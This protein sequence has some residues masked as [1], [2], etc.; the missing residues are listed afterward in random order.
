MSSHGFADFLEQLQADSRLVR[1]DA[2]IQKQVE[3]AVKAAEI[4]PRSTLF[5]DVAGAQFPLILGIFLSPESVSAAFRASS[6]DEIAARIDELVTGDKRISWL[7]RLGGDRSAALR[8]HQPRPLRTGP[9]QQIVH[10]GRDVDLGI[11]P[12]PLFHTA[13][14]YPALTAGR[15]I[16]RG[17]DDSQL[18]V[19]SHEF[20][21]V[22]TDR[23]V[24]CWHPSSQPARFLARFE[25]RGKAMPIVIA[26]GGDPAD[27]L[28]AMAPLPRGTDVLELDGYLRGTPCEL[29]QGRQVDLPVP[30][31]AEL[32]IEGTIAPGNNCT[33]A[34]SGLD[35]MGRLRRLHPGPIIHVE[36]VT[37]R[38]TPLFPA[39]MPIEK[40]NI[41][42]ALAKAFLPFLR[43][44]L[45]SLCELEFPAFGGDRLWAFASIDKTYPGQA[46]Q[47]ANAFWG[48]SKMLPVR[49]L[50]IVDAD[51]D[52]TNTDSVLHAVASFATPSGDVR[53][54]D[55]IP[56]VFLSDL[57]PGRMVFDATRPLP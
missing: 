39:L 53:I 54:T 27:L 57:S 16:T 20:R 45:P 13:E 41:H 56:D 38:P 23:L 8:K 3:V 18:H 42:R 51:V 22:D 49:Y 30:A 17:P 34:G 47:F 36:A 12:A 1:Y 15:L 4:A 48:L 37:H 35:A 6:S 32:V 10:L 44:E 5:T 46:R 28:M 43:T 25:R 26:F 9:S 29:I 11:L 14:E 2:P 7:E 40:G 24:A 19:G 50:V 55:S 31:D 33:E 21:I 52:L